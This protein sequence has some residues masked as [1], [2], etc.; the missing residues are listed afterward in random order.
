MMAQFALQELHDFIVRAKAATYVGDGVKLLPYRPGSHDLQFHEP[1]FA[2][3][4]S[5][6]GA[7]D[8]LGQEVVYHD[9]LPVW[10]M[11]Y[12]GYILEPTEIE[13]AES[14]RV[15]KASLSKLYKERRFLGGFEH[16]VE[17][18]SYVDTSEGD[19]SH[20]TGREWI[21]RQGKIVYELVYHGGLVKG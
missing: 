8:F 18:F 6:F 14:G 21:T 5:Y 10:V 2:Y 9:S 20:F 1:P 16:T 19:V 4:D 11:N 15:I 13:A 12:Y 7:S 3:H 17:E